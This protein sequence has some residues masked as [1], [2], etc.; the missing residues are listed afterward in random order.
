M[1]T[2]SQSTKIQRKKNKRKQKQRRKHKLQTK[3]GKTNKRKQKVNKDL[4]RTQN[5][6]YNNLI[7]VCLFI[8]HF[9]HTEKKENCTRLEGCRVRV[10]VTSIAHSEVY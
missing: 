1:Y 3:K 2:Q 4:N 5:H 6:D 7:G 9:I 8:N 10:S